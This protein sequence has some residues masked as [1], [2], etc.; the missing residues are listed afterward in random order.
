VSART[1]GALLLV[2][3]ALV[4]AVLALGPRDES[5]REAPA[6][7]AGLAVEEPARSRGGEEGAG[8]DQPPADPDDA[9]E[10]EDTAVAD[11]RSVTIARGDTL[12]SVLDREGVE[13]SE[14][15][16]AIR[17]L[18]TRFSPRSLAPGQVVELAFADRDPH[19][20]A[21]TEGVD[22]T[23]SEV[24]GSAAQEKPRPEPRLASLTLT[25]AVDHEIRVE[26]AGDASFVARRLEK[27]LERR[28]TRATGT[29]EVSLYEAGLERDVPVQVLVAMIRAL[30]FDVDFQR[31]IRRG[32]RFEL[33]YEREHDEQG[34]F[35]RPGEIL[36]MALELSGRRIAFWRFRDAEGVEDFFDEEGRSARKT[37]MRTPL[38]G[39]RLTSSFGRRRHPILGYS[40]MHTGI[41]FG[42]PPGTP[43]YAAGDGRVVERRWRGGYGRTVRI[44]HNATYQTLYAHLRAFKRG[45]VEGTRVEQGQVIGYLGASG[46]VTGPHLHYEILIDGR[47]VNPRTVRLPTGRTLEREAL[48]AFKKERARIEELRVRLKVEPELV[49]ARRGIDAEDEAVAR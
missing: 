36:H 13:R 38:D 4:L 32:D 30:S 46:R 47:P 19:E 24:A 2:L 18:A 48:A 3:A 44:R 10:P 23:P 12:A 5:A 42:A 49:L 35:A 6:T 43:I 17:A 9:E 41:D 25:P 34:R 27:P 16:A 11:R 31:D 33:V 14:A 29:I 26:R 28:L 40:R 1:G 8:G 7:S 20:G 45:V 37:L 21:G 15:A 39:A 22:S